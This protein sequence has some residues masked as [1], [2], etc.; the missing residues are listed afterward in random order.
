M[1]VGIVQDEHGTVVGHFQHT[2]SWRVQ[3]RGQT[4]ESDYVLQEAAYNVLTRLKPG[5]Y[6]IKIAV[7]DLNVAIAGSCRG[8]F[9]VSEQISPNVVA[10]SMVL[11][12]QSVP[13]V[14]KNKQQT[15]EPNENPAGQINLMA[16]GEDA[17][18]PLEVDHR[19]LIPNVERV[20]P[21]DAQL[22]IFLRFYPKLKDDLSRGW[23]VTAS[24]R[25]STGK[26]VISDAPAEILKSTDNISG[27]PV[28]YTFD[29]SQL[30]VQEGEYTAEVE[31]I[32][33]AEKRATRIGAHFIVRTLHR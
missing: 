14:E 2:N 20:F 31:F 22:T 17:F 24:L 27:I 21:N 1:L 13:G 26:R 11:S 25:D 23:K 19:R 6:E 16:G 30:K 33:P 7:A 5:R 9:Q 28:L 4:E 3:N 15:A 32:P 29:L 12:D 18:D 8:F 10:S